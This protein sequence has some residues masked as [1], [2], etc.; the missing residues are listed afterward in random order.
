MKKQGFIYLHRKIR[1]H[2]IF[3]DAE[4]FKAWATFLF[5]ATH[6][7]TK[8]L[9]GNQVVELKRGQFVYGRKAFS[10]KVGISENRLRRF[11]KLLKIEQMIHQQKTNKFSIISITHYDDYQTYNQESTN[12][13][14]TSDQQATTNNNLNNLNN[15][16]TPN[17]S[18][19]MDYF[20]T[21]NKLNYAEDFF[22]YWDAREWLFWCKKTKTQKP[23]LAW[24]RQAATWISNQ[25]KFQDENT[26]A[27]KVAVHPIYGAMN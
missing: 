18:E 12:K 11:I 4:F 1:N 21:K 9:V 5:S 2:W 20:A 25:K 27:E 15:T 22:N 19:V 24:K 3:E 14:P 17:L 26:E 16:K 7:D 6:K 8:L 13:R 10:A 23:I